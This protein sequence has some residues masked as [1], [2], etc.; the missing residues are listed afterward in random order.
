MTCH[1][2]IKHAITPDETS[3]AAHR[4]EEARRC[5]DSNGI[6][7]AIAALTG[8]CPARRDFGP[9]GH[10][11]DWNGYAEGALGPGID[12]SGTHEVT[13]LERNTTWQR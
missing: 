1:C 8:S 7:I 10:S 4:L 9:I 11:E 2:F 3:A 6:L 12:E 13:P 5:N